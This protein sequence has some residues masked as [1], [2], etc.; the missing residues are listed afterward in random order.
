MKK[1]LIIIGIAAAVVAG[2]DDQRNLFVTIDPLLHVEGDWVPS[3]GRADMNMDA[4]AVAYTGEGMYAKEYFRHPDYVDMKAEAGVYDVMIFNGL[5]YEA[6]DTHL[7]GVYFR[8]INRLETFEAVA[9][10]G[11]PHRRL[12]RAEGEYVATNAMEIFTSMTARQEIG[13]DGEYWMKYEDGVIVNDIPEDYIEAELEMTPQAMSYESQVTVRLTNISS[14]YGVDAEVYGFAGSAFAAERMPS[15]FFVTHQL[16]L[17]NTEMT[18]VRADVGTVKS[19]VF[20]TFGP[21][22]DM[23]EKRYEVY[24][25][26]V[27]KDGE[28]FERTVDV[29]DQVTLFIEKVK[30]N[31]AG[32][33]PI[34]YGLTLPL[35]IE[36]TLPIIEP[37]EGSVGVGDWEDDEIIKVPITV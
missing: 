34:E 19:P 3:L 7:D 17:N 13:A 9:F 8:N 21:P 12:G 14:A 35:Y 16:N 4:T 29:T 26:I 2:C 33:D 36:L 31:L 22:V 11:E 27:L 23:P 20:V 18:D 6:E 1:L 30:S 37:I 28:T 15:H 10:E 24:V 5:M 32:N 25:R